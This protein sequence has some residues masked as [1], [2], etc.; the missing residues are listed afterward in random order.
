[1]ARGP[2]RGAAHG[3]CQAQTDRQCDAQTCVLDVHAV[4]HVPSLDAS[5]W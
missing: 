3:A 1:M 2:C 5:L 4:Q